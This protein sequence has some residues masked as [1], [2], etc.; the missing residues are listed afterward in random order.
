MMPAP[1]DLL[2][3]EQACRQVVLQSV[4]A[5]D[6]QDYAAFAALFTPQGVLVRPD[7]SRLE[8]GPAIEAAY[9]RRD[10]DRL[11]RHLITNQIVLVHNAAHASSTCS[12]QLWTGSH[13][14]AESARGRPADPTQLIGEFL[15][16]LAMTPQGW[17]IRQRQAS[18]I[19]HRTA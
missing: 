1:I 15:D 6:Q 2:L 12:V 14:D 13:K 4:Q 17:R 8:G 5:V 19:L 16:E 9:A 7:G 11:T 10:A 3:A 18:F